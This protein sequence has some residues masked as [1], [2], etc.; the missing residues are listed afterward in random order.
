M[1]DRQVYGGAKITIPTRTVL[2]SSVFKPICYLEYMILSSV[3][4]PQVSKFGLMVDHLR[5]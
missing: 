5:R 2:G 4:I 3:L 1:H